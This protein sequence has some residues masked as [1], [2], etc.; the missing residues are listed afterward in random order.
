M[1]K[2]KRIFK[3]HELPSD[4]IITDEYVE[5]FLLNRMEKRIIDLIYRFRALDTKDIQLA[6]GYKSYPNL[7]TAL[8]KLY[9]NRFITR[10]ARPYE[11][12]VE[13]KGQN[14]ENQL[15]HMLD[16]AGVIYIKNY[17]D[18][19]KTQDVKWALRDNEVKYEYMEHVLE[20]A[21]AY[22]VLEA[23]IKN[24][25]SKK[26]NI[27]RK[28]KIVEAWCDRHLYLR[29][30]NGKEYHFSPDAF[31]KYYTDG[32]V[33]GFFVELDRGTMSVSGTPNYGTFDDK[34]FFYEMY[35][36]AKKEYL[37]LSKMPTCLV[38]TTT[39]D[40]AVALAKSV[41]AKQQEINRHKV[42]FLFTTLKLWEHDCF[43]KIFISSHFE[44]NKTPY[45]MFE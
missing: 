28:D 24:N 34:V 14:G 21:H 8:K 18:L 45:T 5:Q 25:N 27:T 15:F 35:A 4:D 22:A 41:R 23:A 40:R 1:A 43:G 11:L 19:E 26:N 12:R 38:I 6:L 3:K 32:K 9:V 16:K 31:Y 44:E 30:Y 7:V 42:K 2:R 29:F 17:Y 20:N 39:K 37:G 33:Y 36:D 13:T 10:R